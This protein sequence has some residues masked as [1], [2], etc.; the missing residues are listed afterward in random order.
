MP[1]TSRNVGKQAAGM[2]RHCGASCASRGIRAVPGVFASGGRNITDSRVS[3]ESG[4]AP[5]CCPFLHRDRSR[6]AEAKTKEGVERFRQ[7][8]PDIDFV[9]QL[10]QEFCRLLREQRSSELEAW[11]ERAAN[12]PLASWAAGLC[13]DF[14]AVQAAF[15]LP[16]SPG[17]V[18][19]Q[20]NRLKR[21]KRQ[22]Y[23]RAGFPLLRNRVL[24]TSKPEKA[25]IAA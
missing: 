4:S 18:E 25:L 6:T 2:A 5:K 24:S 16:W 12:S 21:L 3:R 14:E 20:V 11:M 10:A 8:V 22:M 9:A 7:Q 19:G 1:T 13:R 17:P 23:G 15:S